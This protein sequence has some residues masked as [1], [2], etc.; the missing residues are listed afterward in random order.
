MRAAKVLGQTG[1]DCTCTWGMLGSVSAAGSLQVGPGCL[2]P[3]ATLT[4][5]L[6]SCTS[7]RDSSLRRNGTFTYQCTCQWSA[8]VCR[9]DT[10][11]GMPMGC[12]T[13]LDMHE[14]SCHLVI[15][16]PLCQTQIPCRSARLVR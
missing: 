7:R 8:N 9:R 3:S 11:A 10:D 5:R 2:C 16:S 4:R 14:Q 1:Q 13:S 12:V 6:M 15:V